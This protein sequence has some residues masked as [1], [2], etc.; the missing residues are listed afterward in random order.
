MLAAAWFKVLQKK[1]GRTI[2]G[3]HFS[4]AAPPPSDE[5]HER[6]KCACGILPWVVMDFVFDS[7]ALL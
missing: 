3:K 2:A 7:G 1:F 6:E 5:D 4:K